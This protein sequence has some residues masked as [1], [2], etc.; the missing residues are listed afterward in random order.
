MGIKLAINV[1]HPVPCY[2]KMISKRTFAVWMQVANHPIIPVPGFV[3]SL[4]DHFKFRGGFVS[5]SNM[6]WHGRSL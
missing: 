3:D 4:C 6:S 1:G 2:I 5:Y